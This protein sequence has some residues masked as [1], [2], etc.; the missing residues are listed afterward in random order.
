MKLQA[1]KREI[2]G[3]KLAQSRKEEKLPVVVYGKGQENKN[4]F[5]SAKDFK[6][7]WHEAG[8]STVVELI[9]TGEKHP[10]NVLIHDIDIDPIHNEAVHA[11][12]LEVD[13]NKMTSASV[14]F[15][16]DG[17]A[18]AVKELRGVLVKVMHELEIEALP[19]NLPHEIKVD[20]SKLVT[21]DDQIT[22]GDIKLP[23]GVETKVKSDEVVVLAS[24]PKEEEV[25]ES[26]TIEN[27]EVEKKGKKEEEG[28]SD[29]A[30]K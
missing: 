30:G 23:T 29:V 24:A 25:S 5:V 8:E 21:F 17:V 26:S 28:E 11:D 9:L 14:P 12:F 3:K 4:L 18:P 1:E 7:V 10:I 2:F 20:M 22:V 6:K 13:M 19:K 27:I 16:F 15:V